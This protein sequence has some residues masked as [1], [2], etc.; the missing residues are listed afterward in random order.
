[1][2]LNLVYLDDGDDANCNH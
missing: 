1:L 2:K